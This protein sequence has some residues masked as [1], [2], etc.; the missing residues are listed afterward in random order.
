MLGLRIIHVSNRE[1][2]CPCILSCHTVTSNALFRFVVTSQL[3]HKS[4]KSIRLFWLKLF[5]Y[6]QNICRTWKMKFARK[7]NYGVLCY[8]SGRI[9]WCV[10]MPSIN[11]LDS[12]PMMTSSNE[13]IFRS[14]VDSPHKAQWRRALMVSLI[15]TSTDS[16]ANNRNAGDLRH[17]RAH[18]DVTVMTSN[19][20]TA[21]TI[22]RMLLSAHMCRMS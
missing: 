4:F 7:M 22:F 9:S 2:R 6:R 10:I 20:H 13:H 8:T 18:Y 14:P 5:H 1:P 12:M 19:N 15:L 11:K 21:T 17:H 3:F 16:W